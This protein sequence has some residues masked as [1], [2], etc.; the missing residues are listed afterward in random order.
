MGLKPISIS[1]NQTKLL[2]LEPK[3]VEKLCTII[4]KYNIEAKMITLENLEGLALDDKQ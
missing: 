3:Y 4:Q 2:F 1:V